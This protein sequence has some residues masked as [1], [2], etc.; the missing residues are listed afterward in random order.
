MPVAHNRT[1]ISKVP[2]VPR[3][4]E[5]GPT[6]TEPLPGA[7]W[8]AGLST[9]AVTTTLDLIST[10]KRDSPD[11][12]T[13]ILSFSCGK[14]SVACWEVLR[15]HFSRIVPYYLYSV[16]GLSFVEQSLK[17]Y[18]RRFSTPILRLPHPSRY[19][20]FRA[21]TFMPGDRWDEIEELFA[22]LPHYEYEDV[23]ALVREKAGNECFIGVGVR[24]RDSM[25]RWASYK[26]HGAINRRRKSFYPLVEWTVGELDELFTRQG[27]PLPVD[28]RMFGRS[29]DG[30]DYRFLSVIKQQYPGDYELIRRDFP[31]VDLEI[32]RRERLGRP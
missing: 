24:A 4:G 30:I 31:L 12:D 27:T 10:V 9:R 21:H 13:L 22:A 2:A 23:E 26:V 29:F 6:L 11:P 8:S 1:R 18:E 28:Y 7:P 16:P 15:H 20:W 17:M 3:N 19:R 25:T 5:A 32:F 14:E